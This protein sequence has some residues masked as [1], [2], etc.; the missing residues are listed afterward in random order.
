MAVTGEKE[1]YQSQL[2]AKNTELDAITDEKNR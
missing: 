1:S 2:L